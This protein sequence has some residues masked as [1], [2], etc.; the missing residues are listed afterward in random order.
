[1]EQDIPDVGLSIPIRP[2]GANIG[3]CGVSLACTGAS[4][5]VTKATGASTR[6]NSNGEIFRLEEGFDAT[7]R[8]KRLLGMLSNGSPRKY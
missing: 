2:S 6:G 5:D 8:N 7:N 4:C 3:S 1:M